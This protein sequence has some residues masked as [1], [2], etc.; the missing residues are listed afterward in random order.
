MSGRTT[1]EMNVQ[2]YS[3]QT[4]RAF[5]Q[6]SEAGLCTVL[7]IRPNPVCLQTHTRG[8]MLRALLGMKRRKGASVCMVNLQRIYFDAG[9]L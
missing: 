3:S 7:H 6:V 2:N 1:N 9:F 4:L 8:N 5:H